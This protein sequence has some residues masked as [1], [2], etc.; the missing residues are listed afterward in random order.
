MSSGYLHPRSAQKLDLGPVVIVVLTVFSGMR[1]AA[2][3]L[4]SL[5]PQNRVLLS[6]GF[7]II[8][9]EPFDKAS[10]GPIDSL[11]LILNHPTW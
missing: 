5:V 11:R 6:M 3:R 9:I 7:I 10:R 4:Q 2:L 1:P 8:Y